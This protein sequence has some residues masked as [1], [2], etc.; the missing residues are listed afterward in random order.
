MIIDER[1]KGFIPGRH[2]DENIAQFRHL[3]ETISTQN[4]TKRTAA[5]KRRRGF[6]GTLPPLPSA[7]VILFA[8]EKALIASDSHFLKRL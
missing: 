8:L 1:R 3:I 6:F 7:A 2:M 5:L 4:D